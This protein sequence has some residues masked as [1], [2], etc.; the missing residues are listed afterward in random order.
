[1]H[2]QKLVWKQV[3]RLTENYGAGVR[4]HGNGTMDRLQLS[5]KHETRPVAG[6][7]PGRALALRGVNLALDAKLVKPTHK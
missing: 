6:L 3:D 5:L 7:P 4:I 1:M 2:A